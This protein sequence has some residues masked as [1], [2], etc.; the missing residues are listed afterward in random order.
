MP[1]SLYHTGKTTAPTVNED[2]DAGYLLG[3]RW[4]DETNDKEYVCLDVTAGAAVWTE[5][6]QSGSSFGF[7]SAITGLGSET[8]TVADA[9]TL[10]EALAKV[11]DRLPLAGGTLTGPLICSNTNIE[12]SAGYLVHQN[13]QPTDKGFGVNVAGQA[14]LYVDD[15]GTRVMAVNNARGMR[16]NGQLGWT[17]F[18]GGLA[19][20][21]SIGIDYDANGLYPISDD[22]HDWGKATNRWDDIYA[23]NTTIQSSDERLKDSI[24]DLTVGTNLLRE[25]RPVSYKWK[26][27]DFTEKVI[28]EEGNESEVTKRKTHTRL[29]AGFIAQEFKTAIESLGIPTSAIAAFVDPE[30][31]GKKGPMGVRYTELIPVLVNAFQELDQRVAALEA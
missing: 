23:T 26:D 22:T 28:D 6:T 2:S 20:I 15:G 27:Y 7:S 5:T 18:S 25:L 19:S 12:L 21:P 9:D 30:A 10:L 11:N 24:N 17:D 16:I 8:G 3:D 1:N 4:I 14:S 13:G 29:H 31:T